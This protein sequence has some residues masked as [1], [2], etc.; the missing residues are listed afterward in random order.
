MIN[1]LAL[2]GWNDGSDDEIFSREELIEAFELERVAKLKWVNGQHMKMMS[3]KTL[4]PNVIEQLKWNHLLKDTISNDD[5]NLYELAYAS[6]AFA[7]QM[8]LT[9]NDAAMNAKTV[10]ESNLSKLFDEMN[11]PEAMSI[12]RFYSLAQKNLLQIQCMRSKQR[13][14]DTKKY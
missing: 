10:F 13:I 3:V 5:S 14:K 2:L 8:M 4:I 9:T 12:G 1:Y 7:K 11:D 6:T